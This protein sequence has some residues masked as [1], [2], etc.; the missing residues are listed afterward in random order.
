LANIG[1]SF[2]EWILADLE[3]LWSLIGEYNLVIVILDHSG[4]HHSL[5]NGQITQE[6]R[7]WR[8]WSGS[9]CRHRQL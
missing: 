3:F 9:P 2:P 6:K 5:E 8:P 7:T 1:L 4:K